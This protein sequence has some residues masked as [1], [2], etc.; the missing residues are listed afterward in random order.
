MPLQRSLPP[1]S[2]VELQPA[3][4]AKQ[5]AEQL[6]FE[7]MLIP[8]LIFKLKL[9]ILWRSADNDFANQ[10]IQRHMTEAVQKFH[11][12]DVKA[13]LT[14]GSQ[15]WSVIGWCWEPCLRR[16]DASV[17]DGTVTK[18]GGAHGSRPLVAIVAGGCRQYI[19][20]SNWQL[21]CWT[22]QSFTDST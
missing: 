14:T 18:S 6:V 17:E 10:S 11:E 13:R 15:Q 2:G 4:I 22:C 20:N 8:F 21:I 1:C 12:T 3:R 19:L 7:G 16:V 5:M 9:W